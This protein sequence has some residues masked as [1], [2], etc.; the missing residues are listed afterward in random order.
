MKKKIFEGSCVALVTPF[1]DDGSVNY[2]LMGEL[3]EFQIQNG[4]DAIV[5]CG[6]TG[7][8]ATLTREEH[9]EV[10][11]YTIEK[12]AGRIP[13]I[14]STGSNDTAFSIA[15]SQEAEKMGADGLLL[16]T[17]YYNKTSQKGLVESFFT[18]ADSVNIPCVVYNVPGR[19]G[20][21]ILPDTY[22]KLSAH[23]NIAA[24]KEANHDISSVA[25]TISLC[26]DN[27]TIYSGEDDQ[28]LPMIALGGKGVISVFANI[29]PAQMHQLAKAA[30][31][32][33]LAQARA[34]T[35]QYI[36]LMNALFMDVNPVPVKEALNL[37]G[38]RCGKPRL[39]LTEM[40]DSQKEKLASVMKK[41]GL[42]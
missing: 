24:V 25:K 31:D 13:V 21:N 28:T 20:L 26:G 41:Y 30:L 2:E 14:A 4:T 34:L 17:P 11:R 3:I 23:P 32:G 12:T 39:P 36:E 9:L 10:I 7:E 16:V 8:A 35:S 42:I 37:M 33:D 38:Y 29:L 15:L 1:H 22:Q 19:T 5:S 27:L 6:T 40:T 18:I